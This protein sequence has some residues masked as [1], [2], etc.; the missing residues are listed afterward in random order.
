MF[1][2]ITEREWIEAETIYPAA[3]LNEPVLASCDP[4]A[5]RHANA[6]G[7]SAVS[8]CCT[9]KRASHTA[10]GEQGAPLPSLAQTPWP[11]S[12]GWLWQPRGC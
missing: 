11:A 10:P 9:W 1:H 5:P 8:E 6:A 2:H 7:H 4:T 12:A 3:V